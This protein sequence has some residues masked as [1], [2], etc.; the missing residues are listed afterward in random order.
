M[1][2]RDLQGQKLIDVQV[3]DNIV[4]LTFESGQWL[5]CDWV[6]LWCGIGGESNLS[7]ELRQFLADMKQRRVAQEARA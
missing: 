4:K 6:A 3:E 5:K 7:P 1:K 2:L